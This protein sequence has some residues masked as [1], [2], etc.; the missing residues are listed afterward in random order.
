MKDSGRILVA[1]AVF[2]F[3]IGIAIHIGLITELIDVRLQ[4][5]QDLPFRFVDAPINIERLNMFVNIQ[6]FCFV[7]AFVI[8]ISSLFFIGKKNNISSKK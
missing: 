3:S 6:H 8:A 4:P 5:V 1:I 2:L 7:A